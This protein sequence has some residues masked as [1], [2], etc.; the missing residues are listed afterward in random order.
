MA[1][2]SNDSANGRPKRREPG[3]QSAASPPVQHVRRF[4]AVG[5]RKAEDIYQ[6]MTLSSFHSLVPIK[7]ANTTASC[8]V[9][10]CQLV[11]NPVRPGGAIS[12]R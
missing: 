1:S 10:D 12:F 3:Q 11:K 7:A 9:A 8:C 5:D 4:N 6:D 2:I